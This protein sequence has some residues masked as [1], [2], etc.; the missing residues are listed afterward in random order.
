MLLT[1]VNLLPPL[2][3]AHAGPAPEKLAAV[4]GRAHL[5][6]GQG[7]IAGEAAVLFALWHRREDAS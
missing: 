2:A 1:T 3:G 5:P 4:R 7:D 6:A